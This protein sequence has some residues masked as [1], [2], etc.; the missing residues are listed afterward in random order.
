MFPKNRPLV[1]VVTVCFNEEDRIR[2]T[3]ESVVS[4]ISNNYEW[5]IVDGGSTDNTLEVLKEYGDKIDVMISEKDSGVYNAMNKGIRAS[6]GEF[7]IFINGGDKFYDKDAIEKFECEKE[8]ADINY[9]G[10]YEINKVKNNVKVK[11]LQPVEDY[12]YYL[13]HRC[14]PHQST[15]ISRK[16]LEELACYDESYVVNSDWDF[17]SKAIVKNQSTVKHLSYIVSVFYFDGL[18]AHTKGSL[19]NQE[20][21]KKIRKKYFNLMFRIRLFVNILIS[22]L[23]GRNI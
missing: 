4:Q 14:L 22:R 10:I 8:K 21:S 18:S 13:Y 12:A 6:S 5:I 9:G 17:Y 7:C 11:F 19:A 20:E 2:D 16:L 1:S 3:A 15:F 23:I